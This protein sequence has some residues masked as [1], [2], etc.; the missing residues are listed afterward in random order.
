MHSAQGLKYGCT[1]VNN[2]VKYQNVNMYKETLI[3]Y[4]KIIIY[5]VYPYPCATKKQLM[6]TC[7]AKVRKGP[8]R[9]NDDD[10]DDDDDDEPV[11]E[12]Q[13]MFAEHE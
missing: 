2:G 3:F 13:V 7:K 11:P 10:D 1:Y 4:F 9:P 5:N 8:R 6:Y 12:G